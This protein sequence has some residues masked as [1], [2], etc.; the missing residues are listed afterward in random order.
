[1]PHFYST[2][3]QGT[4]SYEP[5]HNGPSGL[6]DWDAG[7]ADSEPMDVDE[8]DAMTRQREQVSST[9]SS[10]DDNSEQN[11]VSENECQF[12]SGDESVNNDYFVPNYPDTM[13]VDGVQAVDTASP[14]NSHPLSATRESVL[15]YE[16]YKPSSGLNLVRTVLA[17][18]NTL[19]A[20]TL[21]TTTSPT[22]ATI[23]AQL[24]T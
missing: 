19:S 3:P 14:A 21:K 11:G 7:S 6:G 23:T 16:A 18:R 8:S 20:T 15:E 9:E 4:Q 22:K 17:S 2:I 10:D 24:K 12:H 13:D 5:S 1:M